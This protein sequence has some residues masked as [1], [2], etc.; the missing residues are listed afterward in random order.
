[1]PVT[2]KISARLAVALA[3]ALTAAALI[4]AA[5]ALGA[6]AAPLAA[7]KSWGAAQRA[8]HFH[9]KHPTKTYGLTRQGSIHVLR[10][11]IGHKRFRKLV[12]ADYAKGTRN[13]ALD[14][15]SGSKCIGATGFTRLGTDRVQG[16]TAIM[17]GLCGGTGEPSCRT[18]GITLLLTWHNGKRHYG[19][20]SNKES[21]AN[22]LGFARGLR[23][24]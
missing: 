13:L 23:K 11:Q 8:A 21:R 2:G 4:A 1:M 17:Y 14:Q 6:A 19:A 10:C 24:V 22:L 18:K 15:A 3:P 12:A 20:F 7:Y 5:P 16:T 9:L